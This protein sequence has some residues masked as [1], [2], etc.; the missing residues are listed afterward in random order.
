MFTHIN[1][2]SDFMKTKVVHSYNNIWYFHDIVHNFRSTVIK[3]PLMMEAFGE[4]LPYNN[5]GFDFMTK[6]LDV[7]PENRIYCV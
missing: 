2:I 3:E 1:F 6:Y 4:C 7:M 5:H